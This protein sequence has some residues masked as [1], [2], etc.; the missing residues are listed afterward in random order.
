MTARLTRLATGLAGTAL[1]VLL[2]VGPPWLLT[3]HVGSPVPASWPDLELLRTIATTGV[4][5][6]FLITTLAIVVWI[7]WTQLAIALVIET[8]TAIRRRPA[9]RLPMLPGTQPVAA[10][11]VAA[12]LLLVTAVQPRPLAAAGPLDLTVA[13]VTETL[14]HQP[15]AVQTSPAPTRTADKGP[16][17]TIAVGERDSWWSLAETHLGDGMRWRELRELNTTR[18]QPDGTT[19]QAGTDQL[20]PGWTLHVPA[21]DTVDR[22][23]PTEPRPDRAADQPDDMPSSST[24]QVEPDD[25]F[26]HIATTAL[27]QAW[28][29]TPDDHEIV[30]FWRELIDINRD[31]LAP[32]GDPDLIHPGQRFELPTPPPDPTAADEAGPG[33]QD[34][35]TEDDLDHDAA[36]SPPAP[37]EVRPD[38]APSAPAE[39]TRPGPDRDR[40]SAAAPDSWE[41][42]LTAPPDVARS[43]PRLEAET[44]RAQTSERDT[45]NHR[46]RAGWGMPAG[47]TPGLGASMFLA[48]GAAALIHR[49]RRLAL[50]QR[51]EHYRLPTLAPETRET[52]QSLTVSAPDDEPLE[53]LVDL[54]CSV[55]P[56]VE[57]VLVVA[58]DDGAVS[59]LF[60]RP[61]D[62]D[63]PSPWSADQHDT[64]P[65]RWTARLGDRGERRSFG[66]P[67]LITLGR[68]EG[69]ILLAN[70]GA[71]RHL[72]VDGPHDQVRTRL[73]A[74][75][76]EV[77]TSRTAGPVE[78]AVVGDDLINDLAQ[79][80]LVDD[81]AEQIAA[82][83]R[84]V[85]DQVI[86]DDRIPRLIIAHQGTPAISVPPELA[87]LCGTVTA[88]ATSTGWRFEIAGEYGWIHLPDGTRA[89][90]TLPGL[91]PTL[92]VQALEQTGADGT[93]TTNSEAEAVSSGEIVDLTEPPPAPHVIAEPAWCEVGLLGP[94]TVT[95]D[96]EPHDDLTTISRQMLAY[97]VT[98][99]QTTTGK[100][101]NAVWHGQAAQGGGQRVRSALGRLRNQ[102]GDGPDGQPL[103]PTRKA[104]DDSIVLPD[105]VRSDLDRT[106]DL[107][108]AA[109]QEVGLRRA[110]LLL[111]ALRLIRGEP[112]EDLPVSWAI[113]T[114]QRLIVQ[115]Q[116]A[117]VTAAQLFREASRHGEAEE[118]IRQGLILCDPCE[119]LYIEWARLE[120]ARGR[121]EQIPRLWKRLK[122][123]Y[124]DEGD[125]IA[126]IAA[127]PTTATELAFM[128][129]M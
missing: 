90:V 69:A 128:S 53:D 17:R 33:L 113:D 35:A 27:E 60:D 85:H 123:R 52:I 18:T 93:D 107:V 44:P 83:R 12:T 4:T 78:V 34:A 110:E 42:T 39:P 20:Q 88:D 26:W 102:L 74:I 7:A 81:P 47:L 105:T 62:S 122:Q 25:H 1:T 98:H 124:A 56:T 97:L 3:T 114:Q 109:R 73:R 58:H 59:L 40:S 6:T 66:M 63:P 13:T 15:A 86:L 5:D 120:H 70:L 111:E 67:L 125:E 37:E 68:L 108:T 104:G 10:Q 103:V 46:S 71:M 99:R 57:P 121:A 116:E 21:T 29:R 80:R 100:L 24:W 28:D 55:P 79:V 19:I 118:A 51:S 31:R 48:A 43:Q 126:G 36:A 119:A 129:M 45:T 94:F 127:S 32:P 30:P 23:A 84:E 89:Q 101:E 76:L 87:P 95:K 77:A 65:T 22:P 72:R 16:T 54:L 11:L 38:R 117:A 2:L 96:H 14:D 61:A 91:D 8:A 9:I 64:E 112:L 92:I 49:R 75:T 50:L 82:A 115:L 41:R 106:D